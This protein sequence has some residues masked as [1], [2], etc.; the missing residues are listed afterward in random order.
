MAATAEAVPD[1]VRRRWWEAFSH[2]FSVDQGEYEEPEVDVDSGTDFERVAGVDERNAHTRVD[3]QSIPAAA[4][5]RHCEDE[6]EHP[7][8]GYVQLQGKLLAG[9]KRKAAATHAEPR[10]TKAAIQDEKDV[11]TAEE[12]YAKIVGGL[13]QGR[14]MES[15][16]A[17]DK[18]QPATGTEIHDKKGSSYKNDHQLAA[19]EEN[20]GVV[21]SESDSKKAA[22]S[23]SPVEEPSS[24]GAANRH[25][26]D[27]EEY[28]PE[29]YYVQLQGGLLGRKWNAIA[30]HTEPQTTGKKIQHEQEEAV[31]GECYVRLQGG[32]LGRKRKASATDSEPQITRTDIQDKQGQGE[33]ISDEVGL[34]G[35]KREATVTPVVKGQRII[36]HD[37]SAQGESLR[38]ENEMLRQQLVRKTKELEAEQIR[39]LKLE[40]DKD[41][42]IESLEKQNEELRAENECYRNTANPPRNPRLFR[43]ESILGHCPERRASVSSEQG[44]DGSH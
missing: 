16:A 30:T 36:G 4:A 39:R 43:D 32:L 5:A 23:Q 38:A 6:E 12:S 13:L 9:T 3:E 15:P 22:S 11:H 7:G 35:R 10:T 2:G 33:H 26:D 24:G 31:S 41:K 19:E 1:E 14:M 17:H 34:Q 25:S 40:L 8:D 27:A 44:Y 29:H 28:V 21:V 37:I 42:E 20:A 18:L